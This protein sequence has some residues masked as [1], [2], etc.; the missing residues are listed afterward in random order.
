MQSVKRWGPWVLV[1]VFTFVAARAIAQSNIAQQ[2][3]RTVVVGRYAIYCRSADCGQ[4]L[5]LDTNTGAVWELN[6]RKFKSIAEGH[7]GEDITFRT[8]E[9]IG[10]EGIYESIPDKILK[11]ELN[12]QYLDQPKEPEHP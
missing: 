1:C 5:L 6:T 9:R 7:Q 8:F 11:Q 4:V 12:Q 2:P 3:S 10:V